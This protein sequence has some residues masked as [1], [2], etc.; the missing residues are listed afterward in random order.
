ML[1]R[2]AGDLSGFLTTALR[3][4]SLAF[5]RTIGFRERRPAQ[6]IIRRADDAVTR[7]RP[8]LACIWLFPLATAGAQNVRNCPLSE[9]H[10]AFARP[11]VATFPGQDRIWREVKHELSY[12]HFPSPPLQLRPRLRGISWYR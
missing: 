1:R 12:Y 9:R 10:A 8:A 2:V 7:F 4:A 3:N 6:K 5:A 11:A